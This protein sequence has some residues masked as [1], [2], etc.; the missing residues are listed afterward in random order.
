MRT[1]VAIGFNWKSFAPSFFLLVVL[2]TVIGSLV[3]LQPYVMIGVP[4]LP[5][6]LLLGAG[7][8]P[9]RREVFSRTWYDTLA[10]VASRRTAQRQQ[11]NLVV[12]LGI[13]L[14]LLNLLAPAHATPL[15]RL[16]A[17][18]TVV[19][20]AVPALLWMAGRDRGIPFLPFFAGFY[21][22]YYALPVFLLDQF[23][24]TTHRGFGLPLPDSM[25]EQAL[26]LSLLGLVLLLVGYYGPHQRV[27]ARF[28]PRVTMQ[29]G[30]VGSVR[31]VGVCLSII[32]IVTYYLSLMAPVPPRIQQV[33]FF[34]ADLA[35]VFM[36][37]LFILQL[38][39]CL[40]LFGKTLLW[41]VLVPS[42]VLIGLATGLSFQGIE[43]IYT[44]LLVYATVRHRIPWKALL[45]GCLLIVLSR[46]VQASFRTLT[47]VEGEAQSIP[48]IE[49]VLLYVSTVRDF[50]TTA[51]LF[52]FSEWLPTIISR[53][54]HVVAFTEVLEATPAS[55]PYWRGETYYSLLFKPV[56]RL[57]YPDKPEAATG[58][59]FGHRYGFLHA[60]DS[61]TSQ[62]LPQLIEL[63]A[64]F[65]VLGVILGMFLVGTLYRSVQHV[66]VHPGM[67]LG[68]V[69]SSTSILSKLLWME[70]GAALVF[71]GAFWSLFSLGL[72]HGLMKV[73]E[74]HKP[75]QRV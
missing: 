55:V 22:I 26:W 30:D 25:V 16:L 2:G 64:N 10:L 59:L 69:L 9:F 57:L 49:K 13:V 42:R 6:I 63:Y 62:N 32:G 47:W 39:G 17:S 68:A 73:I 61:L 60:D 41:V 48:P 54:A 23:S 58:Q 7:R 12:T 5:A 14:L 67:G 43:V 75:L 53:L 70:S 38:V 15:Q 50:T 71:G 20:A 66:L 27:L 31:I 11:V 65:G 4:L 33:V 19:V 51:D 74:G 52:A 36:A 72:I 46:P 3:T 21:V 18:L 1:S 40:G 28:L 45:F 34:T 8:R 24:R 44:L 29:W 37:M 56:P 35:L